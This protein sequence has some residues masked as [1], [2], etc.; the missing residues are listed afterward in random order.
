[1]ILTHITY[2]QWKEPPCNLLCFS[3]N[4]VVFQYWSQEWIFM[5]SE[6]FPIKI[7]HV[8]YEV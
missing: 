2:V 7:T 6:K 3:K 8:R 5:A 1:M 4:V